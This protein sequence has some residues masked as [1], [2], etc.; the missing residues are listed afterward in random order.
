MCVLTLE[1]SSEQKVRGVRVEHLVQM[2]A[3]ESQIPRVES[4]AVAPDSESEQHVGAS[5]TY[6]GPDF[7]GEGGDGVT[8]LRRRFDG[9]RPEAGRLGRDRCGTPTAH[10]P[11]SRAAS[12]GLSPNRPRSHDTMDGAASSAGRSSAAAC[13]TSTASWAD[14]REIS[15]GWLST[16][17]SRSAPDKPSTEIS[18]ASS[19]TRVSCDTSA[20]AG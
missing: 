11:M 10:L 7:R 8:N 4:G 12:R 19:T 2:P 15:D 6:L 1:P 17:I 14:S 13:S 18:P 5:R 3:D 9:N 16:A 20:T